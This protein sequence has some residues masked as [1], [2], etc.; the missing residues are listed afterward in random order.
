MLLEQPEHTVTLCMY[1][2]QEFPKVREMVR[3]AM[4]QHGGIEGKINYSHGYCLRHYMDVLNKYGTGTPEQKAAKVKEMQT[5]HRD[6]PDL[7][8]HPELV[9]WYSRGIF[10]P[11]QM[12]AAQQQQQQSNQDLKERFQKLAGLS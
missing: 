3:A 5:D 10:T 2:E 7:R 6:A 9:A 1:C 4:A 12:Q 11:E 8:Q